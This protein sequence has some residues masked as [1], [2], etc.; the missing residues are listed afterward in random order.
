ML[1]LCQD[2]PKQS[3]VTEPLHL[4][5][6]NLRA[7]CTLSGIHISWIILNISFLTCIGIEI[8][9]FVKATESI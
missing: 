8:R 2:S 4:G 1:N 3:K 9:N 5:L 6:Y 7:Q